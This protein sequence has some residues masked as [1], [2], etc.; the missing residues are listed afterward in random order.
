MI[1]TMLVLLSDTLTFSL[2]HFA[3]EKIDVQL[4]LPDRYERIPE[5]TT[6]ISTRAANIVM[7]FSILNKK[8]FFIIGNY[9]DAWTFCTHYGE[10]F[11][12]PVLGLEARRDW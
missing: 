8:P 7:L 10:I 9:Q 6:E 3:S 1:Y 12:L 2:H 11:G 4:L 5:N